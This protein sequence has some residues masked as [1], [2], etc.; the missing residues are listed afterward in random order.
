MTTKLVSKNFDIK[1]SHTLA[2]AKKNGV[3][4]SLDKLFKLKPN[5]VVDIVDD[6][7]LR[8]KGGGGAYCGGKWKL[9]PDDGRDVYLLVNADES[10]PGTF[11]DRHIMHSDPHLLIEGIICASYAIK[12]NNAYIYI[13][14]EFVKEAQIL[15]DAIDEAYKDGILG[16]SV[17]GI[18][19]RWIL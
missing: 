13:R 19:L 7:G 6:S 15:Q 9:L 8:G 2:V 4:K 17:C 16:K 14:G 11:K 18:N 10:E 5:E 1:D 12:A 3:Y